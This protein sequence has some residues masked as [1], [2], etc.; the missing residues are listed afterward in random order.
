MVYEWSLKLDPKKCKKRNYVSYFFLFDGFEACLNKIDR[1]CNGDLTESRSPSGG[2]VANNRWS[3]MP[4]MPCVKADLTS[5]THA[6][7]CIEASICND[8]GTSVVSGVGTDRLRM[9]ISGS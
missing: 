2:G 3:R 4:L 1:G 8:S 7:A 9:A 6:R 5:A